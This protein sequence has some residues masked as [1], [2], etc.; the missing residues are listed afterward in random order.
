MKVD[1]NTTTSLG[2]VTLK[3]N[4]GWSNYQESETAIEETRRW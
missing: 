1:G 2:E 4:G 3:N